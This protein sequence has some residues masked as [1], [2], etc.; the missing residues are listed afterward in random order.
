MTATRGNNLR[1]Y[2]KRS[3]AQVEKLPPVVSVFD[4]PQVPTRLRGKRLASAAKMYDALIFV[5]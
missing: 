3:N 2:A 4:V 5:R 1:H